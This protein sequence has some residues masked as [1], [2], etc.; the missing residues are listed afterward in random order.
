M[1]E[2]GQYN[3]KWANI[4]MMPEETVQAA[5]DVKSK[6]TMPIHW[7]ACTLAFHTW[8]EPAERFTTK[9][10]ELAIEH[11]VPVIGGEIDWNALRTDHNNWWKNKLLR[12]L[13]SARTRAF[14]LKWLSFQFQVDWPNWTLSEMA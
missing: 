13:Y 7:G 14:Y 4:H 10:E 9:S 2:C 12:L 5:I 1:I 11:L 8:T 6:L 3:E